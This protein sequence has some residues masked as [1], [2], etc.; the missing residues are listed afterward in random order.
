VTA[1]LFVYGTLAPD[2]EAWSLLAPHVTH[3][4]ENAVPGILYDTGRGYPGAF[5]TDA[6]GLVCGWC[7]TLADAPLGQLDAFEGDEYER[8]DVCCVDGTNA[9]AY[10]WVASLAG[11][12]PVPGGSWAPGS[13]TGWARRQ[14][15]DTVP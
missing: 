4:T 12:E 7:C 6:N 8:V 13:T 10:Q 14:H 11:C 5:F 9:M 2:Q 3:M 15:R 1:V